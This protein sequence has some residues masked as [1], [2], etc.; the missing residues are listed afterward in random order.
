MW[1]RG[2][3]HPGTGSFQMPWGQNGCRGYDNGK[4]WGDSTSVEPISID[5]AQ[6]AVEKYVNALGYGNLG[7]V[8]S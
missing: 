2:G 4:G 8:K 1:G 3:M 7:L 5:A 6:D